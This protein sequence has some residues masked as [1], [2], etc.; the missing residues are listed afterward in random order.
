MRKSIIIDEHT[1]KAKNN[2]KGTPHLFLKS[3][4]MSIYCFLKKINSKQNI[5]KFKCFIRQAAIYLIQVVFKTSFEWLFYT[6]F[7][8]HFFLWSYG[9]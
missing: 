8:V 1:I 2:N 3:H 9:L 6:G 5:A 7:T 4:I